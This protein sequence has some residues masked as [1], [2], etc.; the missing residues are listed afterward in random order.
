MIRRE[1]QYRKAVPAYDK[2]ERRRWR[3]ASQRR[4]QQSAARRVTSAQADELR[5]SQQ[6]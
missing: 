6:R 4:S 2:A 5:R 1:A 3:R